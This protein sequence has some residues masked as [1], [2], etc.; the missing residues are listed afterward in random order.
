[1]EPLAR[2]TSVV[3]EFL[4]D[5]LPEQFDWQRLVVTYPKSALLIAATAGYLLGR[6]RGRDLLGAAAAAVTARVSAQFDE[7]LGEER[8]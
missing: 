6:S 8:P 7:L 5:V 2:P 3:D 4:D 1:M